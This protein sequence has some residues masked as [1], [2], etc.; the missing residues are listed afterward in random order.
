MN[1]KRTVAFLDMLGFKHLL[2]TESISSVAEKYSRLI[3]TTN[4]F[5]R[6]FFAEHSE[7]SLFETPIGEEGYCIKRIFSD[8]IILVSHDDTEESCLKLVIYVWKLMQASLSMGMPFRGG[9]SYDEM[10]VDE[11]QEI[12]LGR[13][14]TKAYELEGAQEWIGVA[15]NEEI[16]KQF[17]TLF[18]NAKTPFLDNIFLKYPVPFKGGS[19]RNL[20]TIN[21]RFNL[22]VEKGTRSLMPISNDK[23]VIK[24]IENTLAYTKSIIDSGAIYLSD[25]A[26]APIEVRSFWCGGK[27]PPF[28]HGDD[29]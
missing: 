19:T 16:E 5:N 23:N 21:W 27:E 6:N 2:S 14:L 13:A 4:I 7:P 28:P 8:S 15:I 11:F 9:I 24:K 1:N 18:T 17:P 29:L 20:R 10:Y 22:I 26:S 25:Q 3:N 12:F